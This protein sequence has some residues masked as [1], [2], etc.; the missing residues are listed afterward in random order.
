MNVPSSWASVLMVDMTAGM[1]CQM[2]PGVPLRVRGCLLGF[3]SGALLMV[4]TVSL[5][6]ERLYNIPSYGQGPVGVLFVST[7]CGTG[8]IGRIQ[9]VAGMHCFK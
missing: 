3:G 4:L 6:G 9:L 1:Y 2:W 5:F 7:L 8:D